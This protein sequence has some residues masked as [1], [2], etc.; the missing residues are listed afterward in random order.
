MHVCCMFTV[1][2]TVLRLLQ[3][4]C[5]FTVGTTELRLLQVCCMFTVGTTV[6]RL[7]ACLLHVRGADHRATFKCRLLRLKPCGLLCVG[8]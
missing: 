6:L 1:G 5:M 2:T 8:A 4:C 7:N 3:V